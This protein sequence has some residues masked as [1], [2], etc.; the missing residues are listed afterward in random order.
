MPS[1]KPSSNKTPKKQSPNQTPNL[2]P[3]QAAIQRRAKTRSKS[4]TPLKDSKGEIIYDNKGRIKQYIFTN[5]NE[6]V[7]DRQK[8]EHEKHQ[9]HLQILAK[10]E[11]KTEQ[12]FVPNQFNVNV[13]K[14]QNTNAHTRTRRRRNNFNKQNQALLE[15]FESQFVA[16]S[17]KPKSKS[18][19]HAR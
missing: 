19:D 3:N 6:R 9:L 14:F 10:A 2:I 15:K 4:R 11:N 5:K 18:P 8:Q 17:P 16:R 7:A 13:P 12:K 1:P